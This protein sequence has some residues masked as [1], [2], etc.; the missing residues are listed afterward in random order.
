MSA[1]TIT[2]RDEAE[3]LPVMSVVIDAFGAVCTRVRTDAPYG[4]VRVTTALHARGYRHYH[5]PFLPASVLRRGD[6][7]D[8][9]R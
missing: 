3:A 9:A 1:E 2:T 7:E 5:S 4:W 8:G 6:A